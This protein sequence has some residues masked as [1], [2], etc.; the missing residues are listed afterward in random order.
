[1]KPDIHPPYVDCTFTCSCGNTVKTRAI[2]PAIHV[3]VC[4]ACH[5]FY[6]QTQKFVDTAGRVEKFMKK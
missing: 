2:K 4:A 6:T 1:M 3:E 5:P